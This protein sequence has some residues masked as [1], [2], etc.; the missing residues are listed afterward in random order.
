[1]DL[2]CLLP[3]SMPCAERLPS[4]A[5]PEC[6]C[7]SS[8]PPTHAV[9]P[10]GFFTASGNTTKCA[11][12]SYRPGGWAAA[13]QATACTS[14]GQGVFADSDAEVLEYGIVNPSV[15]TR[16]G[17]STS[18]EACCE[19]FGGALCAVL[20]SPVLCSPVSR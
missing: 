8:L 18:V 10:P 15:I 9:T 13:G 16:V 14:C 3:P 17:V 7:C 12:G 1:M 6:V 4:P 11:A 2:W 5:V 20:S 19:C